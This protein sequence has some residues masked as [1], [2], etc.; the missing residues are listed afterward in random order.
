MAIITCWIRARRSFNN[1]SL[2][3]AQ[4][5]QD[6]FDH[7]SDSEFT[8]LTSAEFQASLQERPPTYI[9]SEQIESGEPPPETTTEQP[10]ESTLS[11]EDA[12]IIENLIGLNLLPEEQRHTRRPPRQQSGPP[13]QQPVP[14]TVR[15]RPPTEEETSSEGVD[16]LRCVG[17]RAQRLLTEQQSIGQLVLLEPTNNTN[18][19]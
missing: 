7:M 6:Y 18:S 14:P 8:P 5:A 15:P 4:T 1:R 17:V 11:R 12:A 3:S 2:R 16:E 19:C 9:Q 13:R 10:A